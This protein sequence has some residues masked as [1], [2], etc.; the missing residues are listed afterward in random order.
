MVGYRPKY[1]GTTENLVIKKREEQKT[2]YKNLLPDGK[3]LLCAI[4]NKRVQYTQTIKSVVDQTQ[5]P[6]WKPEHGFHD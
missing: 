5:A 3:K 4:C 6:P 2:K 1:L